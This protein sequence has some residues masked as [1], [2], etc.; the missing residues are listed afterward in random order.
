MKGTSQETQSMMLKQ[1][2]M[3]REGSY[4]CGDHSMTYRGVE[5][6]CCTPETDVTLHS[7]YTQKYLNKYISFS[8]KNG[9]EKL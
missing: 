1:R 2:Y 5:S 8:L 4:T 9:F 7:N 6:L 3:G